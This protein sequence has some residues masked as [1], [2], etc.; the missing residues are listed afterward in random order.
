MVIEL[1]FRVVAPFCVAGF[2]VDPKDRMVVEAAPII[3]YLIG[4]SMR[5]AVLYCR[6]R[7]WDVQLLR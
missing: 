3:K 7:G 2:V 4:R 5:E 6:G 1:L